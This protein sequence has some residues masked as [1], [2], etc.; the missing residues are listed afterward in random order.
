MMPLKNGD[1]LNNRYRI[2]DVLGQGGM[3]AVYRATD[4][5]LD[6][7]VAVKENFFLTDEYARQFQREANI[8][9][10]LRQEFLIILWWIRRGSIW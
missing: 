10:S 9:A 3:G 7:T 1:L 6:V 5:N 2:L 4:E 8:L